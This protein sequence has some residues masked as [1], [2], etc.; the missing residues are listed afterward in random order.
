[1][2]CNHLLMRTNC[3]DIRQRERVGEGSPATQRYSIKHLGNI[4]LE[5]YSKHLE[6]RS[7]L[8]FEKKS[9]Q[10]YVNCDDRLLKSTS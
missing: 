5:N 1:M 3:I 6:C 4:S 9:S 10:D 8:Y 7:S 2:K